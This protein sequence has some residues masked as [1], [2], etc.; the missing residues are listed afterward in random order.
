ML[1][2]IESEQSIA[3]QAE[4]TLHIEQKYL[5]IEKGIS[6][7]IRRTINNRIS[8]YSMTVKKNVSG[9]CIEIECSISKD[10]FDKLWTTGHN[11]VTKIRYLYKGWDIDFFKRHN[12]KN[13]IAIAEIE[14]LPLQKAPKFIP[15]IIK[16]NIIHNVDINDNRFSNKKLGNIKYANQLL[17]KIKKTIKI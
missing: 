12:G 5:T 7:R 10:D 13:Y 11:K 3:E 14:M 6:V 16:R 17:K 1:E 4:Q 8:S 15:I 9:Q 2:T